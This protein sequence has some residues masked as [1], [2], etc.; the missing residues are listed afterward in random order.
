MTNNIIKNKKADERY[1]SIW[2]FLNWIVVGACIVVGALIFLNVLT[3]VRLAEAQVLSDRLS[4]CLSE[5]FSLEEFNSAGFDIYAKCGLNKAPLENYDLY[6][7]NITL[8]EQGSGKAIKQILKGKGT[9]EVM[10]EYQL[11]NR[12]TEQNFAQ[13]ANNK[14]T[15]IDE[16]TGDEYGLVIIAASNQI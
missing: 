6:Y 2:M 10:C 1:L 8:Q 9:F 13:C 15:I 16:K 5:N 12:K 11:N 3:D 7:L 14:L 4:N